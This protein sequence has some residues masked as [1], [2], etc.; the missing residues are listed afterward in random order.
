MIEMYDDPKT[1]E[2]EYRKSREYRECGSWSS[3]KA[4]IL[5]KCT[6]NDEKVCM[7]TD[8]DRAIPNICDHCNPILK[9][10]GEKHAI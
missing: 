7:I 1:V 5:T 3:M 9:T 4:I 10:I 2:E 6:K 8:E